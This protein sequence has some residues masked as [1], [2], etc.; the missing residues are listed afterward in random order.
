MHRRVLVLAG[1]GWTATIATLNA[2][3]QLYLPVWVRARGI[4]IYLMSFMIAQSIGS[5]I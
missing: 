1:F 3:L 2:E 5:P 4:A